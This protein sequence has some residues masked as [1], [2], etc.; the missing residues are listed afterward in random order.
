[1]CIHCDKR[2]Y[3]LQNFKRHMAT[4]TG[5][6]QHICPHCGKAF[7]DAFHL[8][9]HSTSKSCKVSKSVLLKHMEIKNINIDQ[10]ADFLYDENHSSSFVVPNN[11][12][13]YVNSTI[14]KV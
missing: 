4:H 9:R 12:Q 13:K 1:M 5:D 2:F 10:V 6:K 8:K 7:I 3:K 14:N 11:I